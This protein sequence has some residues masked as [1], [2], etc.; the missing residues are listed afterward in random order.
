MAELFH[1]MDERAG[2]ALS[3][4]SECEGGGVYSTEC[5]ACCMGAKVGTRGNRAQIQSNAAGI[6]KS[7]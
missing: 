5:I 2:P 6:W 4:L 1:M 3:V 7:S